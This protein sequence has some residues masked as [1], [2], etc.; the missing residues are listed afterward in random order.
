MPG[1]VIHT[2]KFSSPAIHLPLQ[3]DSKKYHD[4]TRYI[5]ILKGSLEVTRAKFQFSKCYFEQIITDW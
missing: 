2:A 5:A 4:K 1:N 3:S